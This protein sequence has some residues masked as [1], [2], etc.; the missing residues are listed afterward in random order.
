[1]LLTKYRFIWLR[2][3]RGEDILE[4]EQSEKTICMW[5]PCLLKDRDE[6]SN[7]INASYKVYKV[8]LTERFQRKIF[9]EIRQ[10][11]TR[12]ACGGP[13]CKQIGSK[14]KLCIEGFPEMLPTKFQ[15]IWLRGFREEY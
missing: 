15:F 4:I 3:F 8:Y 13:V 2:G 14:W 7:I 11:E 10:S 12:I 1:M 9:L 6:K 5:R